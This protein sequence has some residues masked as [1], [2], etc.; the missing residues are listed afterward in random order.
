MKFLTEDGQ[1]EIKGAIEAIENA[2]SVEVVAAVR[3]RLAPWPSAHVAIGLLAAL[4]MLAFQLYSDDFEF[5]YWSILLL[6]VLVGASFGMLVELVPGVQRA[7]TSRRNRERRLNEGARAAFYDLGVH[8]TSGRTGLLLFIAIR[9]RRA[10]LVGDVAVVEA[11]GPREL[12]RHAA[13]LAAEIPNGLV[14]IAKK[15]RDLGPVLGK[16]LPK[17][18]GD[19]DELA[20]A[21]HAVGRRRRRVSLQGAAK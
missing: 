5:D 18:A 4:G 12:D 20:N 1:R 19:I 17:Q 7:L 8:K 3:Q 21:V 10:A 11:I 9:D 6:P 14:A 13:A 2:S 15:L 16:P